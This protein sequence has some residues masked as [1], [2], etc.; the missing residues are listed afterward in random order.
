ML[1]R[2]VDREDGKDCDVL[3]ADQQSS[4]SCDVELKGDVLSAMLDKTS[5]TQLVDEVLID[6]IRCTKSVNKAVYVIHGYIHTGTYTKSADR[7]DLASGSSGVSVIR[8]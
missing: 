5:H 3:Y 8:D 6:Y 7:L 2:E 4:W 1:T